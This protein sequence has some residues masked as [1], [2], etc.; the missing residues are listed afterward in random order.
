MARNTPLDDLAD[1]LRTVK[2]RGLA[3]QVELMAATGVDQGTISRVLNGR[4]R[5]MTGSLIRLDQ[6]VNMLIRD[7][8]L[9]KEV[10]DAA[11]RFLVRG[12]EAELIASIEHSAKLVQGKLR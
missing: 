7:E 8:D 6:Y 11:R 2:N 10:E 4:R 1:K 5:R 12:T 9:S 3:T